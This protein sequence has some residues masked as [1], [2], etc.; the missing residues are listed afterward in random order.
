MKRRTFLK[1]TGLIASSSVIWGH[2][3][4]V[5][6][7]Q[8]ASE[9]TRLVVA[10][11]LNAKLDKPL[12]A[13]IIG[14][15]GR[16][17]VYAQYADRYPESLQIVGVS[18]INEFRRERMADRFSVKEAYRLGDWSEVFNVPKFAD[19]I[20]ITTPDNLHYEPCMQA[21]KMGYHVL[22]EKPAAQ[23]EKECTDILAQSRKY[24][25]IVAV[26]HVL[27]YAPYFKAMKEAVSSGKIGD[28][29]SIHHLEPIEFVHFSHSYVRGNWNNSD[30]STPAV[31]SKSC[32]D[33]DII[34]WIVDK[35][36]KEVTAFG[37]QSFFKS[38]NAPEEATKRCLD[39]P[40]ERQ[41]AFSAKKIY[42]DRRTWL[43]V[44]DLKGDKEQQG[45]QILSYL[46]TSDYGRCVFYSDNN[47]PENFIMNMNFEDGITTSFSMQA[48]TSYGDRRT[49]LMGTKGDIVGDMTTFT[50]TDFLTEKQERW[51]G[52]STDG[53]GGGDLRLIRDLLWAVNKNDESLLTSTIA[54]SIESHVMGFRAERSRLKGTM[55]KL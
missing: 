7:A 41:C 29:L 27:R 34:R 22:L 44:F 31:I 18:D 16:G 51:D 13:I 15:G 2:T 5:H 28:L 3:D 37:S 26:C 10:D 45:E 25:R 23:T 36:C 8:N 43:H 54:A 11:D 47:Q 1:G 9:E 24:N 39:C 6:A 35:P 21:L 32:H 53:H 14:A 17:N 38:E 19:I 49:R 55:E 33:L 42:Y 52:G 12:T 40:I 50:L 30:K 46:R 20:F 4:F 48:M